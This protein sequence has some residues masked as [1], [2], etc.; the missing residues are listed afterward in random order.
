MNMID[1]YDN[2]ARVYKVH[3]ER[4]KKKV[5]EMES[6]EKNEE[7][8]MMEKKVN[9]FEK[10]IRSLHQSLEEK[11]KQCNYYKQQVDV[12]EMND[13]QSLELEQ[14]RKKVIKLE[15]LKTELDKCVL[16]KE[17]ELGTCYKN[18]RLLMSKLKEISR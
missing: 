12:L 8:R 16:E 9:Q 18:L 10:E 6:I 7:V 14:L 1:E 2:E 13:S 4:L 5:N 15:N 3:I 11:E 17:R